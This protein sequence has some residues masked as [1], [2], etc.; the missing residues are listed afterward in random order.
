[1]F[2]TSNYNI[3]TTPKDEY[4]IATG[5]TEC[6][7]HQMNGPNGKR[8]IKVVDLKKEM[9]MGKPLKEAWPQLMIFEVLALV[10]AFQDL[11]ISA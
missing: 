2:T 5:A 9:F 1:M 3:T 4:S 6:P 10:G 8:Q 11:T 7:V